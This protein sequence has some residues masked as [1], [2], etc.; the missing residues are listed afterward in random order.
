MWETVGNGYLCG[1][2]QESGMRL[3]IEVEDEGSI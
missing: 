2:Y 1:V 3:N